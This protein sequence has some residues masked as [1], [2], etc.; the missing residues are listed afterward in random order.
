MDINEKLKEMVTGDKRV[1][2]V[3]YKLGELWYKAE[4]GF[5][6]PVPINDTGEAEFSAS[7]KALLFMRWIRRHLTS[8]ENNKASQQ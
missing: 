3:K 8:I 7:D 4:N 6:F 2:F 5:E 1:T